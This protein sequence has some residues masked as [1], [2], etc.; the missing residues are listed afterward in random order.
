MECLYSRPL[1]SEQRQELGHSVI[2]LHL[3]RDVMSKNRSVPSVVT[4]SLVFLCLKP[5]VYLQRHLDEHQEFL[6]ADPD[7]LPFQ[8]LCDA[9]SLF[10]G[11]APKQLQAQREGGDFQSFYTG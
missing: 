2:R 7:A 3:Q 10:I 8:L 4:T 5:S 9:G 6:D 11:E 1:L